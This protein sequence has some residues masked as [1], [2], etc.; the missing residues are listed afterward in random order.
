MVNVTINMQRAW[1]KSSSGVPAKI[2]HSLPKQV[3]CYTV[4]FLC[5]HETP[6]SACVMTQETA[7]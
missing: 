2:H 3:V 1:S 5:G 6:L 7:V 4:F